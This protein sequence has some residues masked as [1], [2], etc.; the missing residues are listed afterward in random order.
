MPKGSEIKRGYATVDP[1]WGGKD[2]RE[3]ARVMSADGD[4]MNHSTA[5][6]VFL[7][8]MQNIAIKVLGDLGEN[9]TEERVKSI[10]IHPTFQMGVAEVLRGGTL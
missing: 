9:A 4:Q 3:I 10:A 1:S 8:A 6:N 7:R 2:F 5:R